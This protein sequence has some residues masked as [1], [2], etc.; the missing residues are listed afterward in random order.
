MNFYM[1]RAEYDSLP[2]RDDLVNEPV[3][4]AYFRARTHPRL[5]FQAHTCSSHDWTLSTWSCFHVDL[6]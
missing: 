3:Q 6:E 5:V 1:T 2:Y 4:G